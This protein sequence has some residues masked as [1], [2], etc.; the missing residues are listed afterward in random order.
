MPLKMHGGRVGP[1]LDLPPP[2]RLVRLR[3]GGD[4][5]AHAKSIAATAGAGTFVH[6]GR[7]DLAEFAVV[8]E[9][10]EPLSSARRIV[11]AGLLALRDAVAMQAPPRCQIGF[12]WAGAIHVGGGLVGGA[13]LAWPAGCAEQEVPD[14]LV[15]AG[16]LRLIGT[17]EHD[18]ESRP[19]ALDEAGFD[20]LNSGQLVA[21]CARHLLLAIDSWQHDSFGT[22]ATGYLKHMLQ[23]EDSVAELDD[24][25]D[26]LLAR[27][28]R[29]QR[30]RRS[31]TE[32]LALTE[33]PA[34]SAWVDAVSGGHRG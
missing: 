18:P 20:D 24:N 5:F 22:V 11:Y 26:L 34:S 9:P 4:A 13:R 14:W 23:E 16:I 6:V 17:S 25:G 8:L 27:A 33:A 7:F 3:E 30:D 21:D 32:A 19:S 1:G 2:Y 29:Q 31:L 28:G 15:F 10:N 12:V